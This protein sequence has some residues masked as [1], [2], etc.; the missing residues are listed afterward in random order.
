MVT[1]LLMLF[2]GA[3]RPFHYNWTPA[4]AFC[5]FP[6]SVCGILMGSPLYFWLSGFYPGAHSAL[7]KHSKISLFCAFNHISEVAEA[8]RKELH[9]A[10]GNQRW[11]KFPGYAKICMGCLGA[12]LYSRPPGRAGYF[13]ANKKYSASPNPGGLT[14]RCLVNGTR[15][16]GKPLSNVPGPVL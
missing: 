16:V 3:R 10:G 5:G 6:G 7:L 15:G 14:R 11:S 1:L 8:R 13:F 12:T 2:Q 9:K 4:V